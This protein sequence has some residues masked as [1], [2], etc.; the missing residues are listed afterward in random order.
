[1]I[2]YKVITQTIKDGSFFQ[3]VWIH[4]FFT[5]RFYKIYDFFHHQKVNYK[6]IVMCN[7]LGRGYGCNPK[8]L[9]EYIINNNLDYEIIWLVDSKK[10]KKDEIFPS[11]IRIVEYFSKQAIKEMASAGIWIDNC[12]KAFYPNKK[13]QQIY[14]QT[15]HGGFVGKKA[16]K[17]APHL[18]PSYVKMAKK[19]SKIID[20]IISDCPKNTLF[21]KNSFWYSGAILECGTPRTDIF[22]CN[23]TIKKLSDNIHKQYMIPGSKKIVLYAPTFRQSLSLTPYKIDYHAI[24]DVIKEKFD[25][26]WQFCVRL[27]PNLTAKS[28]ELDIP[29]DV[30][31][32][33]SYPDMQEILCAAD[34][35][36]TDYSGLMFDYWYLNRPIFLFATDFKEYTKNDREFYVPIEK[37]PFTLSMN[38]EQ[39]Q[40]NIKSFNL[41]KYLKTLSDFKE[42]YNIATDGHACEKIISWL[43]NNGKGIVRSN[44]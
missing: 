20:L 2:N 8:Y 7:F 14:V 21:F 23:E 42:E 6:K 44:V 25:G 5:K 30:I 41:D 43:E 10:I 37:L 15:W 17:D 35:V 40:Q 24:L 28:S 3:K 18:S 4:L 27:H 31:D 32:L 33:S 26:E 13:K 22:F 36:I 34:I 9:A 29:T 19:D 11:K 39:L 1:M 38:N 16:E 12:R